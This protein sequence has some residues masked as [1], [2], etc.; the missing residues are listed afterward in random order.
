MTLLLKPLKTALFFTA[1]LS[2]CTNCG[3]N[4]PRATATTNDVES[5]PEDS[6]AVIDT[7]SQTQVEGLLGTVPAEEVVR[8]FDNH[9][10]AILDCYGQAL[11]EVEEI[12]GDLEI[13]MRV[14]PE[15]NVMDAYVSKGDLGSL[16]AETCIVKRV[17]RFVFKREHGAEA[18]VSYSLALEAPY[19]PPPPLHWDMAAV[20]EVIS[21]HSTDLGTCLKGKTGI[22]LTLWVGTGGVVLSSGVAVSSYESYQAGL[23]LAKASRRWTFNDPGKKLAKVRLEL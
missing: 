23:C 13:A 21:N 8:V 9:M 2:I 19:D 10:N 7:G 20:K 17:G 1:L 11:E 16:D 3:G 22:H 12:E 15:G 5:E 18:E 6:R 14:D 4:S